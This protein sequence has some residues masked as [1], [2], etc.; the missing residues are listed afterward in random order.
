MKA[1]R[2][3]SVRPVKHTAQ[4]AASRGTSKA[5]VE[6]ITATVSFILITDIP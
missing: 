6:I 1:M 4:A 2:V 5:A 3:S